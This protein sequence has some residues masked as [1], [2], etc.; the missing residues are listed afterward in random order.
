MKDVKMYI[1]YVGLKVNNSPGAYT[2]ISP[3]P[4][5]L[6]FF[7]QG[8]SQCPLEPETPLR[9]AKPQGPSPVYASE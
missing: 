4:E 5:G 8:A 9:K 6:L 3:L 2:G 7:F 1:K